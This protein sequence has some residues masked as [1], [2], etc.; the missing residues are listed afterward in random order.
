MKTQSLCVV[1]DTSGSMNEMGKIETALY[2]L[3]Y[4]FESMDHA[5]PAPPFARLR[6]L[7]GTRPSNQGEWQPLALAPV[8]AADGQAFSSELF[9]TL[10]RE[11]DSHACAA[12]VLLSD[13]GFVI[14]PWRR[15]LRDCPVP[16]HAVM[17]GADSQEAQLRKLF[18]KD[19][20]FQ[21]EAIDHA[22]RYWPM[23]GAA[24]VRPPASFSTALAFVAASGVTGR[25]EISTDDEWD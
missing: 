23:R 7:D 24:D 5:G 15:W 19:A 17:I 20:V 12:I 11:I 2:L 4:M 22:W 6:W 13:G 16:I 1:L 18:G 10:E 3:G 9:E 14:D 25:A 8:L 21:A